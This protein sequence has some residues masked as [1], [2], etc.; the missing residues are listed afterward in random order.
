MA[1]GMIK[2]DMKP[3]DIKELYLKHSELPEKE[4]EELFK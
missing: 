3:M 2:N 4:I 1:I